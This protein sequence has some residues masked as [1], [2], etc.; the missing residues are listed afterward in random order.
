MKRLNEIQQKLKCAKNQ[1]NTFGKYNY[2][3]CE[4]ILEAVK[5]LLGDAILT[6]SDEMVILGGTGRITSHTIEEAKTTETE[7]P[8]SRYYIKATVTL[9]HDKETV[10][11]NG[12]AREPLMR[13]GMDASQITGTASS[14]ARKYALNGL[15]CIDDN[16]DPDTMKTPKAK[17]A[18]IKNM[19]DELLKYDAFKEGGFWEMMSDKYKCKAIEIEELDNGQIAWFHKNILKLIKEYEESK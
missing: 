7:Y 18:D 12:Y 10:S 16:K 3:S 11:A 19:K 2:R 6:L 1:R 17:V 5:P 8:D 4:D 9:T 14:Y 15:F 13:K